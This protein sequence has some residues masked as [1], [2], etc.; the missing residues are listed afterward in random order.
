MNKHQLKYFKTDKGK[1]ALRKGQLKYAKSEKGKLVAKKSQAKKAKNGYYKYGKGAYNI[2][3]NKAKLR[4]INFDLDY[5]DFLN[6][7]S[8]GSSTCFYCGSTLDDYR[9]ICNKLSEYHGSNNT[10]I[11]LQKIVCKKNRKIDRLTIDRK[12]NTIG[13]E[14]K[15][16]TKACM[17]CNVIKGCFLN[18]DEMLL[19][20]K[21]IISRIKNGI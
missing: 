3:K 6:W 17:I 18:S 15:N 1:E 10:L 11:K 19:I 21:H 14:I 13:Y 16:M 2:L 20:G 9:L 7:W 5:I 8:Y 4:G 12:D